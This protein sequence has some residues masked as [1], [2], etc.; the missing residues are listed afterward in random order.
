ML[1]PEYF[2]EQAYIG[3]LFVVGA[4]AASLVALRLWR[5]DDRAAWLLGSVVAIGMAA[6]FVLSR[7]TG[8]SGFHE[9]E[10]EL[11]GVLSLVL[12]AGFLL[13]ARPALGRRAPLA[14]AAERRSG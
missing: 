11:S 10:W 4:G 2:G 5:S 12:E 6:G 13:L 1:A 3:V 8:L 7:T 9:G 14:L